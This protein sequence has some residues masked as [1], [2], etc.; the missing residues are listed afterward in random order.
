MKNIITKKKE[1]KRRTTHHNSGPKPNSFMESPR[2]S[3]LPN[4][5]YLITFDSD[6]LFFFSISFNFILC[7]HCCF[8][9]LRPILMSERIHS[10]FFCLFFI[11]VFFISNIQCRQQ[12]GLAIISISF[13]ALGHTRT[14]TLNTFIK[15]GSISSQFAAD[16][17]DPLHMYMLLQY[18]QL[19]ECK[20]S[21]HILRSSGQHS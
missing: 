5:I 8:K 10:I 15:F 1:E 4:R 18:I 19:M 20:I 9:V 13:T 2:N 3:W 21:A 11:S 16:F 7:V 12:N 14:Q 6:F 17:N